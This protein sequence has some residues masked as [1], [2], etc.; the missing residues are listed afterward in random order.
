[1]FNELQLMDLKKKTFRGQLCQKQRGFI[2][3]EAT[4]GYRS[5]PVGEMRLDKTGRPRPDG[6]KM[7]IEPRQAAV[8]LRI[9]R[10]FAEGKSESRIV[11]ELNDE[12]I[13]GGAKPRVAG[14]RR[15][16]IAFFATRS[17][18]DVGYGTSPRRGGI[19]RPDGDDSSPRLNPS[20]S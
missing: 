3:G 5:V 6:Y 11:K 2:A 16:C 10:E 12:G 13:Q 19:L 18:L 17:T 9:F 7:T 14:H 1:V 4:F 15:R 20:G 8:V